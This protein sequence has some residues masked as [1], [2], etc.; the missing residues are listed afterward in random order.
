MGKIYSIGNKHGHGAAG[1]SGILGTNTNWQNLTTQVDL[2]SILKGVNS[3][4][5]FNLSNNVKKYEIIETKEDLLALSCAWYRIRTSEYKRNNPT[6]YVNITSLL[7]DDL[8]G[9][10]EEQDRQKANEIRD[11]YS[12]K[13]L[14]L[15]LKEITL[16]NFR[17][18]LKDYIHGSNNKFTEKIVPLV[19][20]LPEFYAYDVEF[21]NMKS[22]LVREVKSEPRDFY[23]MV[24]KS[25]KV[26]LYPV[27]CFKKDTKR[28]K[29]LEYWFRDNTNVGYVVVLDTNNPLQGLWD[30]EFS[31]NSLEFT[32]NLHP[33]CRDDFQYF[34]LTQYIIS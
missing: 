5:E 12:K 32:T 4:G 8:F 27:K 31:K 6:A 2:N 21:E 9:Y 29:C 26:T 18:D 17:Q 15:T 22:D 11:Y 14:M 13:I 25:T 20:R 19:Y 33:K 23:R 16:T 34:Q 24:A 3:V 28:I 7:S 30:R 10:V 1:S